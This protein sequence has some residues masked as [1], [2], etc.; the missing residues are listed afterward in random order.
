MMTGRPVLGSRLRGDDVWEL[1]DDIRTAADLLYNGRMKREA[2][3]PS[4]S[5]ALAALFLAAVFL[6][7]A[8]PAA[9]Q[10]PGDLLKLPDDGDPAT[11]HDSAVYYYAADGKRYVFPNAAA[12]FTWYP[13][14]SKVKEVPTAALAAIPLGGNVTYRAGTRLVKLETDPTVYAVEP[15]GLLRAIA[16]EAVAAAL[17]GPDW[18]RRV[19]DISDAFFLNYRL[20]PPLG[21]PVYPDGS[22]VLRAS[23]GAVFLISEGSKRRLDSATV[24]NALRIRSEFIV[25]TSLDLSVYLDGPA[26]SFAEPHLADTAQLGPAAAP[27]ERLEAAAQSLGADTSF[28]SG[29]PGAVLFRF[30]LQAASAGENRVNALG[31]QGYIDEREG[32]AVAFS[33]GMDND[34]GTPRYLRDHAPLVSLHDASGARLAG[35]VEV[36]S[37]GAVV[38]SGLDLRL[39]AGAARSFSLR[40]DLAPGVPTGLAPDLL[41]FDLVSLAAVFPDGAAV[42][43]GALSPNRG[44]TPLHAVAVVEKGSVSLEWKGRSGWALAGRR[45]LLGTLEA[46]ARHDAFALRALTV[47]FIGQLASIEAVEVE[48]GGISVSMPYPGNLA[49]FEN[50]PFTLG[51]NRKESVAVYVIM[52]PKDNAFWNE[53]VRA[54]VTAAEL[55]GTAAT[56]PAFDVP[57][58]AVASDLFVRFSLPTFVASSATPAGTVARGRE[59]PVLR[60]GIRAEPEG[61]VLFRRLAFKLEPSDAGLDGANND[62]LERWARVN[63]DF[64]DDVGVANLWR[65]DASGGR[66]LLI[67]EFDDAANANIRY[68]V[69]SGGA[70]DET[71]VASGYVS[72]VNDHGLLEYVF[73]ERRELVAPAGTTTEFLLE[74]KTDSLAFGPRTLKVTL[75]GGHDVAWRDL[76]VGTAEPT[77]GAIV[78]GLP[79]ASPLLAVE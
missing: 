16:S 73:P 52:K 75:L 50:L 60:F 77:S 28:V 54:E 30:E 66:E 51:R 44:A 2:A 63:G 55:F 4:I 5:G 8:A 12:Y 9:A 48:H 53:R 70:K 38:F 7:A 42:P 17:Y 20:G 34:D 18:A 64:F 56:E 69:V 59:V 13:D 57:L 74:L 76:E 45:V 19:D 49:R 10:T 35:P 1:G 26:L 37:T 11:R 58:A 6:S 25:T 46:D 78:A 65:L 62:A 39:A 40:A 33:P 47:R 43:T 27:R 36:P 61:P 68:S 22:V 21:S 24:R 23:D 3:L 14:F 67:G 79:L 15:G 71:P 41:A 72:R 31:F 29:T 32:G